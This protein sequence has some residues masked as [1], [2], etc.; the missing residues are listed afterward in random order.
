MKLV[1]LKA[2]STN[3]DMLNRVV[4]GKTAASCWRIG[5]TLVLSS[6]HKD[7]NKTFQS[8][9]VDINEELGEV[10]VES[11]IPPYFKFVTLQTAPDFAVEVTA[12]DRSIVFS[13]FIDEDDEEDELI[14]GHFMIYHTPGIVQIIEGI[15]VTNFG[16]QGNLGR[17]VS[18][19]VM[20]M[21][22]YVNCFIFNIKKYRVK[23]FSGIQ[24][25]LYNFL[26][27]LYFLLLFAT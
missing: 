18:N 20:N 2:D 14:G 5:D 7:M 15:E 12:L 17:Y 27:T 19:T 11:S 23:R 6:P 26:L 4:V 9:I 22:V 10:I 25:Y 24:I 21:R 16:Q 13:A 1:D 3:D 8:L